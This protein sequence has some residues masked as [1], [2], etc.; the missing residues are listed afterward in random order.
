MYCLFL[1]S[2]LPASKTVAKVDGIEV[3][4]KEV[5]IYMN[6]LK[7]QDT[8]GELPT[9][10]EELKSLEANIIDLFIVRKLLERYAKE[11]NIA[12]TDKEISEQVQ[13]IIDTYPSE[14]D[15]EKY[16]KEIGVDKKFFEGE[17][18]SQILSGK[19]FNIVTEDVTVTDDEVRK[20]Y[21]DNKNTYF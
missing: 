5:D 7:S 14:E 9:D 16:I 4:Q 10:E 6:F 3:K 8:S 1:S 21:E 15:F 20:Y 19:I 17:L 18:S 13:S 11:N 12:V 2:C